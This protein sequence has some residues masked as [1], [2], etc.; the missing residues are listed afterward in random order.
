MIPGLAISSLDIPNALEAFR[1]APAGLLDA[2]VLQ[3]RIDRKYLLPRRQLEPLLACLIAD[4]QVV[5]SAGRL[6]ATYDNLYF[7]TPDRRMYE[8]HRRGRGRRYKVRQRHHLDRQLSFLEIKRKDSDVRTV[9]A[10]LGRPF[11]DSRLDEEACAF[12]EQHSPFRATV[13]VPQLS[14]AFHRA[15]LLGTNVIE[16]MTLD[17]DVELRDNG[18]RER[19]PDMAIV[20]IKQASYSN[21]S[22]AVRALRALHIREGSVSKYCLATVTLADVRD[23][24]FKPTL[25][26]VERLSA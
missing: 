7:D 16:R 21:L 26:A 22:P 10:R 8:D 24:T 2:R 5:R 11:G 18:R 12:V 6:A 9:K 25:R 17:W 14:I 1:D 15:T 19:L 13:L 4:Y 3:R 23:N 20:E